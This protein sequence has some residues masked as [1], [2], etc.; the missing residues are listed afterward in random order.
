M[1]DER[2]AVTR[3]E[4]DSRRQAEAIRDRL[5]A[6][7]VRASLIQNRDAWTW[8]V[9]AETTPARARAILPATYRLGTITTEV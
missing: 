7:D 8:Y 2:T 5:R 1:S 3:I 4:C 6:D 9:Y